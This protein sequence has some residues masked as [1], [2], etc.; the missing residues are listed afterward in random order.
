MYFQVYFRNNTTTSNPEG[1]HWKHIPIRKGL[2]A[3]QVTV[4]RNGTPFVVS[5]TGTFFYRIGLTP[6][7][8]QGNT[9]FLLIISNELHRME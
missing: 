6:K 8:P 5:W 3:C 7:N 1:L 2:E 4:A 9:Y